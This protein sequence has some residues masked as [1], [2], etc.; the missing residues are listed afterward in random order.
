LMIYGLGG[1][2]VPFPGIKLIDLALSA[3]GLT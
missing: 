3:V 1:I 2:L